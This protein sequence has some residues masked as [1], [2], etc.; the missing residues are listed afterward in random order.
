MAVRYCSAGLTDI[1]PVSLP[2]SYIALERSRLRS[3]RSLEREGESRSRRYTRATVDAPLRVASRRLRLRSTVL[4][5][6]EK[7]EH[8]AAI[9]KTGKDEERK[10]QNSPPLLEQ[11]ALARQEPTLARAARAG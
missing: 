6:R 5:H 4:W 1:Q 9:G 8:E 3:A 2:P 11:R 7:S 10:E